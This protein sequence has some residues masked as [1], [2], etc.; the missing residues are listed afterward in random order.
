MGIFAVIINESNLGKTFLEKS[1]KVEMISN[2]IHP[3]CQQ[4]NFAIFAKKV[5]MRLIRLFMAKK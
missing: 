5:L 2:L 3:H 1:E 4:D